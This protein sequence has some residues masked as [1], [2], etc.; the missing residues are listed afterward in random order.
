MGVSF[1]SKVFLAIS[2]WF[3]VNVDSSESVRVT[4]INR[5]MYG[6][7]SRGGEVM[8]ECSFSDEGGR[9]LWEI[10]WRREINRR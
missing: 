5:K 9:K 2:R 6:K 8:M 7:K 3:R 4:L 1:I 10:K